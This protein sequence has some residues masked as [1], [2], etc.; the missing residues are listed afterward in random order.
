MSTV[1]AIWACDSGS[2][3]RAGIMTAKSGLSHPLPR[4]GRSLPHP[5]RKL[6]L[7]ELI[8]LENVQ[9]PHILLFRRARRHRIERRPAEERHLHVPSEAMKAEEPDVVLD[10]IER[11]VPFDGLAHARDCARDDLVEA[12]SNVTF[13][14]WHGR[15]VGLY[16]SVAVA[17][18][19]LRIAAR[20]EDRLSGSRFGCG[21]FRGFRRLLG[22]P[23]RYH[24]T[25]RDWLTPPGVSR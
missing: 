16:G 15:N 3:A 11:R 1:A 22:R 17:L 7:I 9:I 8:T 5:I 21:L 12:A 19:D 14:A 18:G 25:S 6:R 13:P 2:F 24:A 20:E 10:A 4:Q 23:A